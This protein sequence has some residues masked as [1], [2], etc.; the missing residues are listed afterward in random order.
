MLLAEGMTPERAEALAPWRAVLQRGES[1]L[2]QFCEAQGLR[3]TLG[4]LHYL[5]HWLTPPNQPKRFDTRFFVARVPAGHQAVHDG[6]ETIAHRW[7]RPADGGG[8]RAPTMKLLTPTLT[9]LKLAWLA[10]PCHRRQPD[11]PGPTQPRVVTL[12]DALRSAATP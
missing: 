8:R 5:S 1:T 4:E 7:M 12:I 3:L 2:D 10:T 9:T 11:G 6:G